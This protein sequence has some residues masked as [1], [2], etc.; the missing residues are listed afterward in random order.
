MTLLLKN[1]EKHSEM[2]WAP[3]FKINF[4]QN[5]LKC[6]NKTKQTTLGDNDNNQGLINN[7]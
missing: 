2:D 5:L 7:A 3:Y 6:P 4:G 1:G